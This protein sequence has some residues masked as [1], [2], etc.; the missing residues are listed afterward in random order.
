MA[1]ERG[2]EDLLFA[3]ADATGPAGK[4]LGKQ[5]GVVSVPSFVLFRNGVRY[6]AV[7]TSKLPSDRLDKAMDD[8]EAGK[9]FDTSLEEDEE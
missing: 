3:K 2:R 5:L 1:R 9:D 6:G 4:A 7:S 8:L